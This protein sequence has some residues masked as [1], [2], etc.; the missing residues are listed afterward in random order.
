[1]NDSATAQEGLFDPV[2]LD[3]LAVGE[4][5]TERGLVP[6]DGGVEIE[7]GDGDVVDLGQRLGPRRSSGSLSSTF[8]T[9]ARS[10]PHERELYRSGRS[11]RGSQV[12]V[13]CHRGAVVSPSSL[14]RSRCPVR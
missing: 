3:R 11:G 9:A 5:G 10:W 2:V 6:G 7:H 1:M 14:R 4:L 12:V 8:S 13:L